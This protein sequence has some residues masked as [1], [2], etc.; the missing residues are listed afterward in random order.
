MMFGLIQKLPRSLSAV[1]WLAASILYADDADIRIRVEPF[2]VVDIEADEGRLIESLVTSYIADMDGVELLTGDMEHD[3]YVLSGSVTLENDNHVLR[4]SLDAPN[5]ARRQNHAYMYKNAGELA[6]NI[7][8]I[9]EEY[10]P[11]TVQIAAL[12]TV[13]GALQLTQRAIQGSWQGTSGVEFAR[14]SPA[15]RGL[16]F[17]SSGAN[18]EINWQI[19]ENLLIITQVSPQNYRYYYPLPESAARELAAEAKP[20]IWRLALFEQGTILRGTWTASSAEFGQDK[21]MSQVVHGKAAPAQ[22][23]RI[24]P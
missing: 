5:K 1:F 10:F 24:S 22:W 14:F 3:L 17:F 9:I 16:V 23:K 7:R 20:M 2:T 4:L 21:K 13:E 11:K 12:H 6:L 18:M 15:G 19:E 8:S